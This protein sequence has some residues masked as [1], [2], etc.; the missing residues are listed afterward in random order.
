L[1]S[2]FEAISALA[3]AAAIWLLWGILSPALGISL[4]VSSPYSMAP[5]IPAGSVALIRTVPASDV[6]VGDL[7]TVRPS[8]VDTLLTKR[9]LATASPVSGTETRTLT[10]ASSNGAS[11]GTKYSVAAVG[12]L[13]A[14]IP[15]LGN[16]LLNLGQPVV[17]GLI[18]ALLLVMSVWVRTPKLP[19]VALAQ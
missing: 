17:V 13:V 7:V 3:A 10:L 2:G 12:T 4:I 1:P 15:G 8:G 16:I 19:Q 6:S 14:S 9:V 18:I 5:Q 11:N